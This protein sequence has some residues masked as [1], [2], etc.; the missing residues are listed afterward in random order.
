MMLL[1]RGHFDS[2]GHRKEKHPGYKSV[3][4]AHHCLAQA[5]IYETHKHKD[6]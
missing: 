2:S 4:L 3:L 5:H 1:T 6:Q